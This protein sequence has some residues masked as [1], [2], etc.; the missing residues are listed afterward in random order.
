MKKNVLDHRSAFITQFV[1]FLASHIYHAEKHTHNSSTGWGT[2]KEHGCLCFK[3]DHYATSLEQSWST[4]PLKP[5]WAIQKSAHSFLNFFKFYLRG[6]KRSECIMKRGKKNS[7]KSRLFQK[8]LHDP[9]NEDYLV[10]RLHLPKVIQVKASAMIK[11][12]RNGRRGWSGNLSRFLIY[13]TLLYIMNLV[14][15]P[16]SQDQTT[17]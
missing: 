6:L 1:A 17:P 4:T 16:T 3:P 8:T 5:A 10:V 12:V 7:L 13:Y 2:C 9:S 14:F 15:S 11:W